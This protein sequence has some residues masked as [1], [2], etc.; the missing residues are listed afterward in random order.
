M[1]G[2]LVMSNVFLFGAVTEAFQN[3]NQIQYWVLFTPLE[4]LFL[5][6]I[7]NYSCGHAAPDGSVCPID[8]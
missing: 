1:L 5:N 3:T 6:F 4:R 7:L 2:I 8:T